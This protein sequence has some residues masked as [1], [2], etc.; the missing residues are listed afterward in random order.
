M[1]SMT[2]RTSRRFGSAMGALIAAATL[3]SAC[4]VK[5]ESAYHRMTPTSAQSSKIAIALDDEIGHFTGM[6]LRAAHQS[7][8]KVG[9]DF[10]FCG[11]AQTRQDST[12]F[13]GSFA[14]GDVGEISTDDDQVDKLCAIVSSARK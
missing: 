8:V 4:E 13:A 3:L 1:T 11:E 10:L 6:G 12:K 2:A 7:M 9:D 14:D 5:A